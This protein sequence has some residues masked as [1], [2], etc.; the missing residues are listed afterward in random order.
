MKGSHFEY[1]TFT[2]PERFR[3]AK[4]LHSEATQSE[5]KSSS[6]SYIEKDQDRLNQ[7]MNA[8]RGAVGTQGMATASS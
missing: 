8:V 6:G 4:E 3:Q 1:Y 2:Q 7:G 5:F